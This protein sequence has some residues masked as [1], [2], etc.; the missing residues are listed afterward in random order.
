MLLCKPVDPSH[1]HI[2]RP[3]VLFLSVQS[4][5]AI[6]GQYPDGKSRPMF[7]CHHLEALTITEHKFLDAY[8]GG[9]GVPRASWRGTR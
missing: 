8:G 7:K 3:V 9:E 1:G 4:A 6:A 5:T 2:D